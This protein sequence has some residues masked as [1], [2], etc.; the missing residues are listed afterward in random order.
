[1]TTSITV[2]THDWP[3][4]AYITDDY[5]YQT[6]A[7]GYTLENS[8]YNQMQ[9]IVPPNSERTFHI[10]NTRCIRFEELPK[11]EENESQE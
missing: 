9:E 1:M 7:L 5:N 10:T 3:V 11:P 6:E 8:V 2:K 4:K